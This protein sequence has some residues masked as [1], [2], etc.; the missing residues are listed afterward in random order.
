MNFELWSLFF[1]SYL[2]I[3]L[4]PGPDVLFVVQNAVKHGYW[5]AVQ[6]ILGNLFCQAII[7]VLIAFGAGTLLEQSPTAFWILKILGGLYLIFLGVTGLLKKKDR[8][9][10]SQNPSVVSGTHKPAN[11]RTGFLVSASNPKTVIFLS[12]FLP[13]FISSEGSVPAQFITM[14]LSICMIVLSVHLLYSFLARNISDAVQ[15]TGLGDW[16]S[17]LCNS[18]FIALGGGLIFSHK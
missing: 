17:N 4:V 9:D 16:F 13:Q 8:K 1:A 2:F 18:A 3:T 6:S 7:V 5:Q 15:K 14:Y 12:A 10:V 11:F